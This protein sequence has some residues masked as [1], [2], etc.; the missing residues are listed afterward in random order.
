MVSR[1]S[2]TGALAATRSAGAATLPALLEAAL[3]MPP[4][5]ASPCSLAGCT[6]TPQLGRSAGVPRDPSPRGGYG[7][8]G[9]QVR[10]HSRRNTRSAFRTLLSRESLPPRGAPDFM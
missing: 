10:T 7:A 1:G 6:C 9:G 3:E 8:R 2:V 5:A 4:A